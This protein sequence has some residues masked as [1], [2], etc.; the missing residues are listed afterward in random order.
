MNSAGRPVNLSIRFAVGGCV[1]NRL[2][3]L[4]PRNGAMMN[5]CAVEGVATNGIRFE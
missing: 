3:K 1:E 4:I 2:P 5:K